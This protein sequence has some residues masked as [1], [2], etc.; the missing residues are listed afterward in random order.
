MDT[1]FHNKEALYTLVYLCLNRRLG[2][3]EASHL[4]A[5]LLYM[6]VFLPACGPRSPVVAAATKAS[7]GAAVG[8]FV[9]KEEGRE[10][11]L[12]DGKI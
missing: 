5:G 4:K 9:R 2:H 7:T 10:A 12:P 1:L 6:E 11:R 8:P 3:G